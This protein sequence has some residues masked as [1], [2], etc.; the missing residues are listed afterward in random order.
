MQTALGLVS[1]SRLRV[2]AAALQPVPPPPQCY[3]GMGPRGS[4]V[5]E[6]QVPCAPHGG[7]QSTPSLSYSLSI[8]MYPTGST[9]PGVLKI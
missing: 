8:Q 9:E 2:E 4:H 7:G 5:R 1:E 3:R 6:S